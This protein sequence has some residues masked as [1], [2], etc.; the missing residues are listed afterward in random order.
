MERDKV[1]WMTETAVLAVLITVTGAVKLPGLVP[2]TEF[3][4]SAPL[5]VA[6]CA[7]FGFRKYI[8][9]GMI[10]SAVGL[11]IGT[12]TIVNVAVAMIFRLVVGAVIGGLGTAWPIVVLAGPLGSAIARLALSG[13]I[14]KAALPLLIAAIPGMLYTAVVAWPLTVLLRKVRQQAGRVVAY[15]VQR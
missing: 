15:V 3:Q 8:A 6:I 10:A 5:A 9:A 11:F 4:L 1:R 2:G 14:G 13:L 7:T 12:Q